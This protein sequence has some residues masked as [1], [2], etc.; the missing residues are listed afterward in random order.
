MEN[1]GQYRLFTPAAPIGVWWEN[2]IPTMGVTHGSDNG[3]QRWM[4]ANSMRC[5]EAPL[6]LLWPAGVLVHKKK[7]ASFKEAAFLGSNRWPV[8]NLSAYKSVIY[9]CGSISRCDRLQPG[10]MAVEAF[11]FRSHILYL[12]SC[13]CRW[14]RCSDRIFQRR[15]VI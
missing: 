13:A 1:T 11:R 4:Y 2:R 6:E 8:D 5:P 12:I 3:F 15:I 9:L 7:G 10:R 14:V